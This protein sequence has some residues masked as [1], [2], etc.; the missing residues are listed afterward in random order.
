MVQ[1]IGNSLENG[2]KHA[3]KQYTNDIFID[4]YF[5]CIVSLSVFLHLSIVKAIKKKQQVNA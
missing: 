4:N 1:S 3:Y 2:K 5:A